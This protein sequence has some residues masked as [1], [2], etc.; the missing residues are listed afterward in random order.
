MKRRLFNMLAGVSLVLCIATVALWVR[1][2]Y[3]MDG[4]KWRKPEREMLLANSQGQ[5][6]LRLLVPREPQAT[7]SAKLSYERTN[8][9]PLLE[10]SARAMRFL[11]F[12]YQPYADP[13]FSA[14]NRLVIPCWSVVAVTA[15]A[16]ML[17]TCH[18]SKLKRRRRMNRCPVCG[19]DLRATPERCPEC[20]THAG[21]A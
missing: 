21:R 3:A 16:P 19:Y 11:G 8:S 14:V 15:I 2:Y 9:R 1:S 7:W 17:W 12:S 6:G 5:I 4:L 20:G 18:F 10:P 13:M